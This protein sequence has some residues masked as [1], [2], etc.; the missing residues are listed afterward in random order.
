MTKIETAARQ[1]WRATLMSLVLPGLGQLYN[2]QVEK[3]IWLFLGFAIMSMPMITLAALYLP[4]PLTVPTLALSLVLALTLWIG[5]MIDA[6]RTAQRANHYL[7]KPWQT[8]ATY[9][10][11]L[12]LCDFIGLPLITMY[13]REHQVEPF[14]VPSMSMEPSVKN[15]DYFF[16]DKRY[17]CPGCKASVARGDIALFANPNNRT[18]IY[19]K[20]IIGLPGDHVQVQNHTV[21]INGVTLAETTSEN[22]VS[23]EHQGAKHWQV[24]WTSASKVSPAV[25]FS[26]PPGQVFVL[27]DN[28]SESLDSR[29]FGTVPLSDVV[30]KA[31][32]VWFSIG[33]DG[34]RFERIG[35]V[36]E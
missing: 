14:R 21:T 26:V 29:S 22:G 28:R 18:Q 36:L 20:R 3:A 11:V 6:W 25:D 31:R 34:V 8:G 4:A 5:G 17:N 23:I 9:F 7:I 12:I 15:G 10:L 2:G 19:V 35:K 27:G 24:K 32:Q 1:P 30:G 33:A 16:A 13:M